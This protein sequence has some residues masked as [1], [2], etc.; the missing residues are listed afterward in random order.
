M[1][2]NLIL[3]IPI[4]ARKLYEK[5]IRRIVRIQCLWRVRVA[6][7]EF[8]KL[9]AEA[10]DVGKMRDLNKGLE[11]KIMELKRKLDEKNAAFKEEKESLLKGKI[12]RNS[13]YYVKKQ[14]IKPRKY[15]HINLSLRK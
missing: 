9:R 11:N 5:N 13:M 10:K 2:L 12:L 7:R 15:R 14:F 8:R 4:S 6:K 3:F 1:V